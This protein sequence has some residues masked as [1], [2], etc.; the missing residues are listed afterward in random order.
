VAVGNTILTIAHALLSDPT[1]EYHDLG[2]DYYENRTHHHREVTSHLRSLQRLGY[3]VTLE[4]T[5]QAA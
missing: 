5:G 1:A 2:P 3:K 4:P